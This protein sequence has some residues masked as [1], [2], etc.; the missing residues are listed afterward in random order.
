[1]ASILTAS[2]FFFGVR[3]NA[4]AADA[5]GYRTYLG[6]NHDATGVHHVVGQSFIA[7]TTNITKIYLYFSSN[8]P[9]LGTSTVVLCSGQPNLDAGTPTDNL[10]TC[11][12]SG[13]AL[14]SLVEIHPVAGGDPD[15]AWI[16][17]PLAGSRALQIGAPYYFGVDSISPPGFTSFLYKN[18]AGDFAA[19]I[20]M[21][22][23][24]ATH[25]KTMDLLFRIYYDPNYALQPMNLTV[26]NPQNNSQVDANAAKFNGISASISSI[27]FYNTNLITGSSSLLYQLAYQ[28]FTSNTYYNFF[29]T[30]TPGQNRLDTVYTNGAQTATDTRFV[31]AQ[32]LSNLNIPIP[33]Q[34]QIC[35]GLD[36]GT[37]FGGMQCALKAT[38]YYAFTPSTWSTEIFNNTWLNF[39]AAFPQNAFFQITDSVE[40]AIASSSTST[41]QVLGVPMLRKTATGTEW[42]V[43]SVVS[44]SSLPKLVGSDNAITI[45]NTLRYIMWIMLAFLW[46]LQLRKK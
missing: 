31:T 5:I 34:A 18:D 30:M 11:G 36:L 46:F 13:S 39:R 2:A 26:Y 32:V 43:E 20:G 40:T 24:A 25:P 16:S 29:A 21:N 17:F 4:Q 27:K 8:A 6:P 38:L 41:V 12:W 9:T 14:L 22:A 45:R 1:M 10:M 3:H 7:S 28:N 42:Y 44:S 19:G 35:A 15:P 37:F 33:T 23:L